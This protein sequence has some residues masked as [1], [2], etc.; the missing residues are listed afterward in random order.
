[1]RI[2]LT[3]EN[4]G[5]SIA[6]DSIRARIALRIICATKALDQQ[7]K[8]FWVWFRFLKTVPTIPVSLSVS[9]KIVS[10]SGLGFRFGSFAILTPRLPRRTPPRTFLVFTHDFSFH[11]RCKLEIMIL[12]RGLQLQFSGGL[13]I[14]IH[15]IHSFLFFYDQHRYRK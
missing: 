3:R 1:M 7:K 12:V 11:Y 5:V 8:Q 2:S 13:R 10:S 15:Y 6:N 14:S 4:H 9:G